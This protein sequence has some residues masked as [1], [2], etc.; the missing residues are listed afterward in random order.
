[1][2]IKSKLNKILKSDKLKC[3]PVHLYS[4]ARDASFYRLIPSAVVQPVNNK[5]ILALFKF[6]NQYGV[7]LTFRAAGTSLSGQSITNHILV[8]IS[9]GW[10]SIQFKENGELITLQPSVIGSHAN[11]A[12][13]KYNRKIG[14]DPASI[15]S[16][17]IGG[18]ISNNAS[19]M[20]CGV[21]HNSYHTLHSM[22]IILP[23]G[24][25]IDSSQHDT[26]DNLKINAS[27][28]F[29][30]LLE[31]KKCIIK[32][33]ELTQTIRKKYS[34]KNTMGY[35]LN[36]FLDF[37]SP[38]DI[39][40][41]LMV[42]AEGTLG[43][44]SEVTL[45]T[46]PDPKFN[47]T[48]LLLFKK[49]RDACSLIPHL[50]KL[51]VD[52]CEIM[53]HSAFQVLQTSPEFP[54]DKNIIPIGGAALLCEF[55]FIEKSQ[56]DRCI[57]QVKTMIPVEQLI[58]PFSFTK[59]DDE[60]NKLWKLRKGML[61]CHAGLRKK[62]TTLI[63][64]DVCVKVEMLAPTMDDLQSLFRKYNYDD[65]VLF[66]H[67][68]DGNLHFNI[69]SDFSSSKGIDNY[70]LFMDDVVQLII[71][72]YNGSLKAE[73][74]TGR[75]MAP[76]LEK[77]WGREA[78]QIMRDIKRLIDPKNI[79]N[80]GV[81]F[82][83]DPESHIKNIKPIPQVNPIID[84]CIECGFCESFCPSKNLTMTPRRRINILR[85]LE[86]LK[87]Q[88]EDQALI[89]SI[90]KS[91][92]YELEDT[93]ATDGLCTVACP[94]NINTGEVIK[95]FRGQ[96]RSKLSQ[97][98]AQLSVNYFQQTTHLLQI[99]GR[100]VNELGEVFGWNNMNLIS[101]YLN[102]WTNRKFPIYSKP[103]R[104]TNSYLPSEVRNPMLRKNLI[105]FPSCITRHF[106][107]GGTQIP[108]VSDR[109]KSLC[110]KAG[111]NFSYPSHINSLCCG[112]PYS[113]KGF[114]EAYDKMVQQTSESLNNSLQN[115]DFII[116]DNSPCALTLKKY[117][118]QFG[119]LKFKVL[120]PIE[121][122]D[123][124]I[125]PNTNII[126]KFE[127]IYFHSPCSAERQEI[128]LKAMTVAQHLAKNVRCAPEP[129][130][131]GFAGD[132]GF[133]IPELTES[134]S[135]T[136]K[137]KVEFNGNHNKYC[138]TSFTCEMGLA[139][140]TRKDFQSLLSIADECLK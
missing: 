73:H 43:F 15:N 95:H 10:K 50:K 27:D 92:C 29:I 81:I 120:D 97:I 74:G 25:V 137:K 53:D 123:D 140:T 52:A 60:I 102:K 26:D 56:I 111:Y 78:T 99:C 36:S 125:L 87:L 35:S 8:D 83:D 13:Q 79:L 93:C 42:G 132:L 49:L 138:S 44:I 94:V 85:E 76:F 114:T 129:A 31:L 98:L 115:G 108:R 131:C 4:F 126:Q 7:P 75:N 55:Q 14:P 101:K 112:M 37:D 70:R 80:P 61:P 5:E 110:Q 72:K 22:K 28:I 109:I 20:C 21:S 63:I 33:N 77:E 130:C 127:S 118:N 12:L 57:E 38:S 39:L 11:I 34:I 71:G 58:L 23:N 32:N 62:G 89:T 121:F 46:I 96:K 16:C 48:A 86:L 19:G 59:N 88:N 47:A 24:T 68:K 135:S 51:G 100:I 113:S 91:L 40:T 119:N 105:Y 106:Q 54:Y 67:A 3:D 1:L 128:T 103:M 6:A 136:I 17:F 104:I 116:T 124:I 139:N 2:F 45:K 65:A 122:L 66:G 133:F 64:E 134:A 9:K 30:G 84:P 41:H 90:E 69:S 107:S 117:M 18:I 82:T